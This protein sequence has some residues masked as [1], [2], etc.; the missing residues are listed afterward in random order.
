MI[1][2]KKKG[3]FVLLVVLLFCIGYTINNLIKNDATT[4]K[5]GQ[6]LLLFSST[7]SSYIMFRIVY[8]SKV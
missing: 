3:A 2:L 4:D 8:K 1:H 5:I 7:I 6:Y